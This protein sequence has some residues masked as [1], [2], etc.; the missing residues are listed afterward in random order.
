MLLDPQRINDLR[1]LGTVR[2]SNVLGEVVAAYL[3][4]S[5]RALDA[6]HRALARNDWV[7]LKESAHGLGGSLSLL[8]ARRLVSL[9]TT[10]QQQ[11]KARNAEG[12]RATLD[13]LAEDNHQLL[14]TLDSL[15]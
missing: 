1:E 3:Q 7:A 4:E 14:A 11:A 9:C 15:A 5:T 6:M 8:G 10:L 2:G 13:S 12:C